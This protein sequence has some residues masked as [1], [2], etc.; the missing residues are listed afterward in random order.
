MQDEGL[1][2]FENSF[3]SIEEIEKEENK[4]RI[5]KKFSN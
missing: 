2:T 1:K 5:R 3:K 4:F